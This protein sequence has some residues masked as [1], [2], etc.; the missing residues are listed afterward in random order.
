MI[1]IPEPTAPSDDDDPVQDVQNMQTQAPPEHP[2]PNA[3]DTRGIDR[4]A[5]EPTSGEGAASALAKLQTQERQRTSHR[6]GG[7]SSGAP[8][9]ARDS[10]GG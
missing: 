9:G 7:G 3:G 6:G 1:N 10:K 5:P 4:T 8:E 2:A